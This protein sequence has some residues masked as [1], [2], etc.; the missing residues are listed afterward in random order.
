MASVV[1][2]TWY[3]PY[4]RSMYSRRPASSLSSHRLGCGALLQGT[5]P[6]RYRKFSNSFRPI[7]PA[8]FSSKVIINCRLVMVCV[9]SPVFLLW[10]SRDFQLPP[11]TPSGSS[12]TFIPNISA[13]SMSA[14][15]QSV[16]GS[17]GAPSGSAL[18]GF[19]T[20]RFGSGFTTTGG[21]SG[22]IS[23]SCARKARISSS[24]SITS[25]CCIAHSHICM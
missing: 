12:G 7:L 19:F 11:E 18:A 13:K 23:F 5:S 16:S 4:R 3:T 24:S 6:N 2:P 22:A 14:L 25:G 17:S 9:I 10:S 8:N 21:S 15:S 1:L 20:S